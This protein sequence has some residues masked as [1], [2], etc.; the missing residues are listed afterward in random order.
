MVLAVAFVNPE[1]RVRRCSATWRSRPRTRSGLK[2]QM[3][4]DV[5]TLASLFTYRV[6]AGGVAVGYLPLVRM[7]IGVLDLLLHEPRIREALLGTDSDQGRR[8]R[9][10]HQGPQLC[11][12]G[13]PDHR[14]RQGSHL[15]FSRSWSLPYTSIAPAIIDY[16][17][18][19]L[20]SLWGICLVLGVLGDANLV[21]GG[22]R[23]DERRPRA[24]RSQGQ[25]TSLVAG[26]R[27]RG[28]PHCCSARYLR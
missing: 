6:M 2:Q 20:R 7:A 8:A 15:A 16:Y 13:H 24:L 22:S 17:P 26:M 10:R 12:G 1:V 14:V 25:D 19:Y 27:R 9:N 23:S 11:P 21:F 28:L 18:R 3:I 5:L 4:I